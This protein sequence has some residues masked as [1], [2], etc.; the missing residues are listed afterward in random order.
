[1][2]TYELADTQYVTVGKIQFAYRRLGSA[3]GIPLVLF[4]H[5]RFVMLLLQAAFNRMQSA[6]HETG[7]PWIIGI[8]P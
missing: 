2:T 4:M 3:T 7:G 8:Q 6:Y 1:M 5:F